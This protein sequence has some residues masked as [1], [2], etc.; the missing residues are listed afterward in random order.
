MK[1][2]NLF[3]IFC[4][5]AF[6]VCAVACSDDEDDKGK[7]GGLTEPLPVPENITYTATI[8]TLSFTWN[9]VSN[10]NSYEVSLAP[11]SSQDS[12]TTDETTGTNYTFTGLSVNTAYV[13]EVKAIYASNHEFDS[14]Y[15]GINASTNDYTKL[16]P[17]TNLRCTEVTK[18]GATIAWDAVADADNYQIVIDDSAGGEVV[19]L[20][21][22]ATTYSVS[23]L[24]EDA[25]YTVYVYALLD[26]G[27]G[28]Y[29]SDAATLTFT[30]G[31]TPLTAPS[32]SLVHK[33]HA[34]AIMEWNI[35]NAMLSEQA[36]YNY[37]NT[38]EGAFSDSYNFRLSDAN[39]NVLRQINNCNYF[40]FRDYPYYR[41]AWGGLEAN[42]TY[43]LEMQ[44]IVTGTSEI[45]GNSAWSAV[46][47]TTDPAPNY[48]DYLLYWDFDNVPFNASPMWIAY[49]FGRVTSGTDDWLNP[50]NMT[51]SWGHTDNSVAAQGLTKSVGQTFF[52]AYLTGL[53]IND[54][55]EGSSSVTTTYAAG[56]SHNLTV[57]AGNMILD[58]TD[59]DGGWVTLP[60]PEDMEENSTVY[61]EIS[62]CPYC[63][64]SNGNIWGAWN[65]EEAA[66]FTV[67]VS[68]EAKIEEVSSD[69]GKSASSFGT[70][71][72]FNNVSVRSEMSESDHGDGDPFYYTNHTLTI[73]GV[74]PE[75]T[76]VIYTSLGTTRYRMWVD[77]IKVSLVE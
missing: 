42:T 33:S 54:Y 22:T 59:K 46:E 31:V 47:V 56:T 48:E 63:N 49:G 13:F 21:Q 61:V 43:R 24:V 77:N 1:F 67:E 40:M 17:P 34:L 32:V 71:A 5:T 28:E 70:I 64:C 36:F 74:G 8:K 51:Y 45:Y 38:Q 44:R 19:N 73:S 15:A 68:D 76:I 41:I 2:K 23:G 9:S 52:D 69:H 37:N 55:Y 57:Q 50:N 16:T 72:T 62:A 10:A 4:V 26:Y 30:T 6:T 35:T 39:G 58:Q 20:K 14:D 11:A 3:K 65:G 75:T 60:L 18:T 29:D 53:D 27:N 7:T 66:S 25:D 12:K